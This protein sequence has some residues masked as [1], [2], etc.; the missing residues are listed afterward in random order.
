M[1][2]KTDRDK[3]EAAEE[4]A[5]AAERAIINTIKSLHGMNIAN[6]QIAQI[7]GKTVDEI[8]KILA[9]E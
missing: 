6:E 9:N 5:K 4:Q 1:Q 7:T 2:A 3:R 8:I